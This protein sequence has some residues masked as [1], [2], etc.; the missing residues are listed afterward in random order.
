MIYKSL[1][2]ILRAWIDKRQ[3][4]E[5]GKHSNDWWWASGLG[6]CRRKQFLR[7]LDIPVTEVKEYRISFLGEEG[8]AGHEWREK[9]VA[10]MGVL[11]AS[12]ERLIDEVSRY[13]G[14]FD[15]LININNEL[16]LVDIKT[17]RPEAF[18]RRA[19]LPVSQRV[20]WYQQMQ[21][22]SYQYFA[23]KKYPDIKESRIYYFDRG[24]G[25]REEYAFRFGPKMFKAVVDELKA[26]NDDWAN[27]IWPEIGT[28][29]KWECKY[30]SW[31][32]ICKS[33]E[34]ENLTINE[35]KKT[36]GSK[37]NN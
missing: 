5:K 34:K 10:D 36:Y 16:V 21:L 19:K 3:S 2:E 29:A 12:E 8:K 18:Y 28:T 24:G 1:D 4:D 23:S 35:V 27:H 31:K 32:S 15:L 25:V 37:E 33:V 11:V 20:Q 17:Q 9:A 7:R 13:R 30:C 26:L 22:A 6:M 14:R